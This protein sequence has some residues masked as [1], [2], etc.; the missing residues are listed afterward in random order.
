MKLSS[1]KLQFWEWKKTPVGAATFCPSPLL[2]FYIPPC[3]K[4]LSASGAGPSAVLIQE[5]S[6]KTSNKKFLEKLPEIPRM[7]RGK[8]GLRHF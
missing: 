3:R 2:V 4:C 5:D 6:A 7:E 1:G 8:Q